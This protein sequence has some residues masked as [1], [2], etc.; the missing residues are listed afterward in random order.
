M[1]LLTPI[2]IM[3]GFVRFGW[4]YPDSDKYLLLVAFFR[5]DV[6][7]SETIPPFSYRPLLPLIASVL[8]IAPEVSMPIINLVFLVLLSWVVF[9][10]TQEFG[11]DAITGF[12]TS[13]VLTASLV[14]AFYGAAVLV[15]AG[16]MFCS[17]LAILMI[18]Q[19]KKD[20]EVATVILVGVLL[21]E[22]ALMASLAYLIKTRR[23][24][25]LGLWVPS[26]AYILV[27]LLM[28]QNGTG[29]I[30]GFNIDAF[31]QMLIPTIKTLVFML[32]IPLVLILL[33]ML[34]P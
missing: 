33:G 27:R 12:L 21:K 15:D 34:F 3:T 24:T 23:I 25:S 18:L 26:A 9:L 32:S 22:I 5:G 10:T 30:W 1:I 11:Y 13:S 7:L 19:D 29:Y 31:T 16:A 6:P 2:A 17:A 4:Q 28:S 8:P 20:W 14:V